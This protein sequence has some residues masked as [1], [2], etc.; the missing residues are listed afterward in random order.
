MKLKLAFAVA[1]F[2]VAITCF[3]QT[4]V[5]RTFVMR[6]ETTTVDSYTGMTHI[7]VLVYADGKYRM[8]RSFQG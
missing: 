2:F 6:A 4:L 7:C 5:E 1:T 3:A 8:E